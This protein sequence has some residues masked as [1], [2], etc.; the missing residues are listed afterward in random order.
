MYPYGAVIRERDPDA[1]ANIQQELTCLTRSAY[2][3]LTFV[4]IAEQRRIKHQFLA[5]SWPVRLV[6][7]SDAQL[8]CAMQDVISVLHATKSNTKR[9]AVDPSEDRRVRLAESVW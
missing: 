8:L 3:L 6:D 5:Q 2:H 4:R 9:L 1:I 7:K